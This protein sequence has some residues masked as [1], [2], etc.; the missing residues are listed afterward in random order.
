MGTPHREM[1]PMGMEGAGTGG[2][3][4]GETCRQEGSVQG[5]VSIVV[6]IR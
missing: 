2:R 1:K 5:L 6:A 3:G 4:V